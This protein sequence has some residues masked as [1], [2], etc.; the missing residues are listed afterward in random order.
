MIELP[1][2]LYHG[3]DQKSSVPLCTV[4]KTMLFSSKLG[5]YVQFHALKINA[6]KDRDLIAIIFC[7]ARK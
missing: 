2:T 5:T 4:E 3:T 7:E 1:I 6:G